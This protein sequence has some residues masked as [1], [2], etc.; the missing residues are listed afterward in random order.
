M[1][2]WLVPPVLATVLAFPFPWEGDPPEWIEPWLYNARERTLESRDAFA[3]GRFPEA[4]EAAERAH[5]LAPE[6]PR[7]QLNLGTTLLAADRTDEALEP[8][9]RAAER[10]EAGLADADGPPS[11]DRFGLAATAHYNLGNAKLRSQDLAGAVEAYEQALRREPDHLDA[12]HNLEV[13]LERLRQQQQQQQQQQQG[14]QG[15]RGDQPRE[16]PP[17]EGSEGGD[18]TQ[19][20]QPRPQPEG[21]PETGEEPQ[22][23]ASEPEGTERRQGDPR[24]PRFEDQPDMSAQEAAAILE[25]VENLEREQRRLEA[26]ERARNKART[27]KDW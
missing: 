4:V 1:K 3:E 6:D 20:E 11:P 24:L 12:K 26:A 23:Q 14:S 13:A 27:E 18:E 7:T 22:P 19:Q 10:L 8:L 21:S 5:R 2:S 15:D 9:T 25:A 17:P 16:T